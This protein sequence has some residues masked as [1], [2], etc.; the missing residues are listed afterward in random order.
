MIY[1]ATRRNIWKYLPLLL[2]FKYVAP[3]EELDSI[4]NKIWKFYHGNV[5]PKDAPNDF[6]SDMATDR[7]FINGIQKAI[8]IHSTI[9]PTFP[10]IFAYNGRFNSG[11]N[12]LGAPKSDWGRSS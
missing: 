9:A 11:G 7:Y 4:T 2:E 10:M 6:I 3:R 12:L 8:Q 1:N 5:A